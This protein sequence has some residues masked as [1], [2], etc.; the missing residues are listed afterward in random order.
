MFGNLKR[1]KNNIRL[2]KPP[3]DQS[4]NDS[5]QKGDTGFVLA[6]IIIGV[7]AV[8]TIVKAFFDPVTQKQ[9]SDLR[10]SAFDIIAFTGAVIGYFVLKKRGKK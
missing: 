1:L 6:L 10:L 2:M 5:R 7:F 9:I 3:V 4:Q 8:L